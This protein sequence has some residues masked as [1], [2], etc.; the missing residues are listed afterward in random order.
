MIKRCDTTKSLRYKCVYWSSLEKSSPLNHSFYFVSK[1]TSSEET[2]E[3]QDCPRRWW[4]SSSWSLRK[5]CELSNNSITDMTKRVSHYLWNTISEHEYFSKRST[6]SNSSTA[7]LVD[8]D[9]VVVV[10]LLEVDVLVVIVVTLLLLLVS[11][12]LVPWLE[13]LGLV[14][15]LVMLLVIFTGWLELVSLLLSL[16]LVTSDVDCGSDDESPWLSRLLSSC[17]WHSM[18]WNCLDVL[19]WMVNRHQ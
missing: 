15:L 12:L 17:S 6:V 8:D 7:L 16:E 5:R 4:S 1:E 19:R 11:L 2:R 9:V 18:S 13:E 10:A 3:A 14:E